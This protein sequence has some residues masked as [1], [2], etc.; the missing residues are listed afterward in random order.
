VGAIDQ[1]A[2]GSKGPPISVR[3]PRTVLAATAIVLLALG[4]VGLGLEDELK[5][6]SLSVP[7]TESWRAEEMLR[8]HFGESAPFAI[9]LRGPRSAIDRQGA[10][11][12]RTLR[13]DPQVTVLSP[14]DRVKPPLDLYPSPDEALVLVDFHVKYD[15]AVS[16]T[17]P[18]LEQTLTTRISP[19]VT[20]RSTS[21]ASVVS[22]INDA[23]IEATRRGEAIAV[24]ILLVILL[25]V[26]RS[27]IAAVIPLTFGAITVIAS[28]GLMSMAIDY[29]DFNNLS[30]GIASMMGLALGVD[31]A[32]LMVSRFREEL[33]AGADP[34]EAA[35]ATRATAGRTV[36]FAGGTLLMAMLVGALL[37]PGE[38]VSLCGTVVAVIVIAVAGPWIV[39]PALL[40]LLGRNI[41]RWRLG[42]RGARRFQPAALSKRALGHPLLTAVAIGLVL[43]MVAA[44]ALSLTT[45]PPDIE[46]LPSGNPARV[47]VEDI[48]QATGGSWANPFIVAAVANRGT[49]SDPKR[50]A[51]LARW[52]ARVEG[53]PNVSAVLGPGQLVDRVAPLRRAGRRLL[54]LDEDSDAFS[55]R[56][57]R[58]SNGVTRLRHGLARASAGAGALATGS[59]LARLGAGRL[60]G[61]LSLVAAGST[62]A[63]S[64]LNR[65]TKG[66]RLL[67][68]G[69]QAVQFGI[70][71]LI[72]GESELERDAQSA[73]SEQKRLREALRGSAADA[74][75][76]QQTS[77]QVEA[78]LQRAW[79]SLQGMS[80]DT[81]DPNYANHEATIAAVRE[82]L[83]AA[84]GVDPATG[85]PHGSDRSGL[86]PEIAA[87]HDALDARA[88]DAGAITGEVADIRRDLKSLRA[89]STSLY[90]GTTRLTHGSSELSEGA[91]AIAESASRLGG[92]LSRLDRGASRLHGG[93][94]RL[95]AGN[96][97]LGHG[98]AS[99]FHRSRPLEVRMRR[100]GRQISDRQ[101][102]LRRGSPRFFDSGYFAL[103]AL[104]GAPPMQRTL[105]NRVLDLQG[106]GQAAAIFV[107]PQPALA[108]STLLALDERLRHGARN[109]ANEIDATVALT[110]A[111]Q[112]AKYDQSITDQIPL[113]IVTITVVTFLALIVILRA[114]PL[115]ALAVLLNLLTVAV[116]F[117]VLR[118]FFEVPESMPF[119]DTD[120]VDAI[121]VAGIFG[122]VFGLS[123]DY[124]VFLLLRMREHWLQH[125]DNNAAI[126]Y[127]LERTASLITGAAAVMAAV[128]LVFAT[129]N[130]ATV[131]QF[132]I[133]LTVAI[134]L[135]ATVIRLALMPTLMRL[136][137]PRV[138]WLP[139]LLE[140]RLPRFD[141]HGSHV[142][143]EQ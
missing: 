22:A 70:K 26:F 143:S 12:A 79:S 6:N 114:L 63:Q 87:L 113:L 30:I 121:G 138:W 66:T 103:S 29:I 57:A 17:V 119:G 51:A 68:D 133:G 35:S 8:D 50:L 19:P 59:E 129:A 37:V 46:Q 88:S 55:E 122:L 140:R 123:I 78:G 76:T 74:L 108:E 112:I 21:F 101:E 16:D 89:L 80:I 58:A 10:S 4:L 61:G 110:G 47:A 1:G 44:P 111:T 9:L 18:Q 102:R 25:L 7:G 72:F 52:Q 64:S 3:R 73:V 34:T 2:Q 135:D 125:H 28:R 49:M 130:I 105:A 81:G 41:D 127:G 38:L 56:L 11:L 117:G 71:T 99:A 77:K 97:T 100:G 106:G 139:D 136:I 131:T 5:P 39:G 94:A 83:T 24:P 45:R 60:A 13:R 93:L 90:Q 128:F 27:P 75:T 82:A 92:G 85:A 23:S 32:L 104:D 120:S 67:A 54:G 134:L 48:N 53:D 96:A 116:A 31:Y 91:T 95:Q 132:G 62:S 84:T 43:L 65:F 69:E 15:V 86:T 33:D 141:I 42:R 107:A 115:A 109:L 124:A 118:L 126:T 40:A 98:L 20:A 137:G 142:R 36:V 14:W